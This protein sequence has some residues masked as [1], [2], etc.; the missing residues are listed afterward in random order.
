[1][2]APT[3]FLPYRQ[4]ILHD[5]SKRPLSPHTLKPGDPH[6]P[7]NQLEYPVAEALATACGLGI[8]FVFTAADPFFFL[9]IDSAWD[10]QSWSPLARELCQHLSGCYI[11]VS[12][13]GRGLHI[14]GTYA[15]L[16]DHA[17]KNTQLGIELYTSGRYAA[18]TG[19]GATGD[20][21][22]PVDLAPLIDRYFPPP[23]AQAPSSE[24]T[25]G[26]VPEWSGPTDD[27][28]LL[29]RML[30]SR[31]AAS[32]LGGRA[33]LADLWT[34][35]PDALAAVFPSQTGQPFDH[36]SA[37][38]ALCAH[39]AFWTGKD[40]ERMDRLMR[41]SGLCRAKWLDREPYRRATI[42]HAVSHCRSVLGSQPSPAATP[43]PA[44]TDGQAT[45]R[46]GYQFLT[47]A[48]QIDYFQ[49]C[50]YIRDLHR[51]LV[52]DGALLK[53]DQFKASYGGYVF[54]LD[55]TAAKTTKNAWEAF[56]ESQGYHFPKAHG[57]CF[58]PECP[59]GA[60]IKE[61]GGTL[62]NTYVPAIVNRQRGDASR[63]TDHVSRLVPDTRDRTILLSYMAACVQYPGVK[64]QWCP[65]VQGCEG[66]GK[67]LLITALAH[68]VGWRYVH[69]PN[70]ADLANKFNAWILGKLLIGVEEVRVAERVELIE[71]LKPL[72]TNS[73]IEIQ[74][75]G[76]NQQTGDN[77]ANFFLNSNWKDAVRKTERDR[78][79]CIF[80]TAQQTRG[81]LRRDGMTGRYFPDLYDWLRAE[82]YAIVTEFLAT[83]PIPPEY[84]PA[85]QCQRAPETTSTKEALLLSMGGLEQEVF[86]LVAQG[87]YGFA[88]GWIS[89][90]ALHNVLKERGDMK[91]LPPNR[92]R[93][94]LN[95]MGYITHPGLDGGRAPTVLPKE[96]GKPVLYIRH[97]H[98]YVGLTGAAAVQAY[99]QAQESGG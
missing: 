72:I 18:L 16:P 88:G 5:D 26:P 48:Q 14:F 22:H 35:D 77:R 68:A 10:G 71:T 37:D 54:A 91:R 3:A 41:Q 99:K 73:R 58:R 67:S 29:A 82:G 64:F 70:A 92:R 49:G 11:E 96:G 76:T 12:R 25:D 20:A 79:Y 56:T 8:G 31:S 13:S 50:V 6:D 95:D 90:L 32:M 36:S 33:A 46:H 65:L 2:I 66:N 39:L 51:A 34:A 9:D 38:A 53:P 57:A 43:Q 81:D 78:R 55:N 27:Q 74:G 87:E 86:E 60:I 52:P 59:P 44:P 30:R 97:D 75:K 80:Y 85:G 47:V 94:I 93:A 83:Y 98:K 4:F 63:F 1:M 89:S 21:N 7:A 84:N 62:V 45:Q 24:W 69:F 28:E 17:C 23:A 19:A 40:C 42:L 15:T 61:E